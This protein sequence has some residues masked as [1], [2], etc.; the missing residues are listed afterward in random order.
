ML[1]I[2]HNLL[3]HKWHEILNRDYYHGFF[4]LIIYAISPSPSN[5]IQA[6]LSL[7]LSSAAL[8]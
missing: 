8:R 2:H 3:L 4:G 5:I 6:P 7:F 1:A